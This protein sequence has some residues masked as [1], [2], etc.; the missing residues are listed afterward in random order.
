MHTG[1]NGHWP[2]IGLAS[3]AAV[4]LAVSG[5]A[6]GDGKMVHGEGAKLYIEAMKVRTQDE[7]R[8]LELLGKSIEL[9]PT[10][11]AYFHRAWIHAKRGDFDQ[12]AANVSEG[13]T[14]EPE[15]PNLLWIQ[16]EL[17]KPEKK[18]NFKAPPSESK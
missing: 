6:D 12:A 2:W 15:N 4:F 16:G 10:G 8:C 14:L 3:A 11:S 18:R 5:C 13:L 7:A 17:N 1:L 9:L